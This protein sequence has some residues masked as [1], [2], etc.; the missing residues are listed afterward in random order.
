VTIEP[1]IF[2]AFLLILQN[3]VFFRD[4]YILAVRSPP[5]PNAPKPRGLN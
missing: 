1:W 3:P 4:T 5:I 2:L